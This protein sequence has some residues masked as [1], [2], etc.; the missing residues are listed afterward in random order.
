MKRDNGKVCKKIVS[1]VVSVAFL[2]T[3][4]FGLSQAREIPTGNSLNT[5]AVD[6]KD[7]LRNIDIPYNIYSKQESFDSGKDKT[8]FH[9]QDAHA[10]LSNQYSI[11]EILDGLFKNYNVDLVLLEGAEGYLDTSILQ[12]LPDEK[13]KKAVA[14][15]LIRKGLLSAGEFFTVMNDSKNIALYGVENDE[16]YRKNLED[17]RKVHETQGVL[18]GMV[19]NFLT[20]LKQLESAVYSKELKD[21]VSIA[22]SHRE[23]EL[24]FAIYWEKISG[25]VNNFSININEYAEL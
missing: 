16:M 21:F 11:V 17:F 19:D 22:R 4:E 9:I 12:S 15:N 3:H 14:D 10:S 23:K 8:I 5:S 13:T 7:N 24:S 18:A 1:L 6:L 25:M 20:Y 2:L